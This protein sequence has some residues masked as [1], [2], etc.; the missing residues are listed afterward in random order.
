MP[1]HG[2]YN[3][4]IFSILICL[5]PTRGISCKQQQKG[6]ESTAHLIHNNKTKNISQWSK[7][8]RQ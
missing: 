3:R 1:Y 6:I 2:D 4:C 5:P 7:P 8:S